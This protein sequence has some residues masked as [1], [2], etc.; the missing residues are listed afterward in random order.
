[1]QPVSPVRAK[2]PDFTDKT[3]EEAKSLATDGGLRLET[4]GKGNQIV[5]QF[6]KAGAEIGPSQRVYVA[7]QTPNTI[8]IP[9]LTG[10]S[11]REALEMCAFLSVNC[12]TSGEGYVSS[13]QVQADGDVQTLLLE[14]LPPEA[15]ANDPPS[16]SGNPA[17]KKGTGQ[18]PNPPPNQSASP[19]P[20]PK[21]TPKPSPTPRSSSS[22]KPG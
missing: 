6:P 5:A 22:P 20:T 15:V 10:R 18:A 1:M 12:K 21:P 16:S 19:K 14:L 11:L 4:Y 2:M 13:Q 3:A 17:D 7:L 8:D 9:D